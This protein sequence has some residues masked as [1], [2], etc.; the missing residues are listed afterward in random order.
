MPTRA[1][2]HRGGATRHS[3]L[4]LLLLSVV[5]SGRHVA[6]ADV[7][8]RKA[9]EA[10][11][12]W[13]RNPGSTKL[14]AEY[15][16][17]LARSGQWLEAL[18]A[19]TVLTNTPNLS[20]AWQLRLRTDAGFCFMALERWDDALVEFRR[21]VALAAPTPTSADSER[22]RSAQA[23]LVAIPELR[24]WTRHESK[25]FVFYFHPGSD[26]DTP[27]GRA[28]FANLAELA[29]EGMCRTLGGRPATRIQ[30][31]V[32]KDNDLAERAFGVPLAWAN[33][34]YY[35]VHNDTRSSKHEI[36][37]II[38]H[39]VCPDEI[40]LA[41]FNEGLAVYLSWAGRNAHEDAAKVIT[42]GAL[43]RILASPSSRA[44]S[45]LKGGYWL[46][47][48]FVGHLLETYPWGKAAAFMAGCEVSPETACQ[49]A[50]GKPLSAL[51]KEWEDRVALN[52]Q[53][54]KDE[55][56]L[57]GMPD[58]DAEKVLRRSAQADGF[59]VNALLPLGQLLVDQRKWPD[60]R[61]VLKQ[62]WE[63]VSIR[64]C[65][66]LRMSQLAA[67]L[68][69]ANAKLAGTK[70]ARS[71]A[72]YAVAIGQPKELA[73]WAH[74]ADKALS[75]VQP[76][77]GPPPRL[78][79]RLRRPVE[80][81]AHESG[82]AESVALLGDRKADPEAELAEHYAGV[83]DETKSFLRK[84]APASMGILSAPD[85]AFDGLPPDRV[86]R[87]RGQLLQVLDRGSAQDRQVAVEY[88][89]ALR[90]TEAVPLLVKMVTGELPVD[91][92]SRWL[93]T[94]ALGRIG[95]EGVIPALIG[96]VNANNRNV[97]YW[98][99]ASLHRLTGEWF[100][101]DGE[102]WARW[103]DESRKRQ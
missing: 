100:G 25:D 22:L 18:R 61:D 86:A 69:Y 47:G 52:G 84:S 94:R 63:V 33:S 14:A 27:E 65:D 55:A 37:H 80:N 26:V 77:A 96:L 24:T 62:A 21:V 54:A 85:D 3:R 31:F 51:S 13:Q 16:G 71:L 78:I 41:A 49:Q 48:S 88:L 70:E 91:G 28:D 32:H 17:A 23:H 15:A 1:R 68:A 42:P 92:R 43:S 102:A 9:Q 97:G 39:H 66:P 50:L 40:R 38:A 101:A 99:R 46:S 60:A 76:V 10:R 19:I 59:R 95:G 79:G 35:Q 36:V 56:Q 44:L 5:L 34:T 72:Q 83:D 11:A 81:D 29:F 75:D 6:R 74:A 57:A 90:C 4:L 12:A 87:L 8:I 89:G 64:G 103:W 82:I 20:T 58:E 73:A 67:D 2:A 53:L 93:A 30:Y 7:W 98:A 45:S